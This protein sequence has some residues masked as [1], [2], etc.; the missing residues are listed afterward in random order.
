[1]FQFHNLIYSLL[2]LDPKYRNTTVKKDL[3]VKI[4]AYSIHFFIS[5]HN[6]WKVSNPFRIRR[7]ETNHETVKRACFGK[8]SKISRFWI[9]EACHETLRPVCFVSVG[10][11]PLHLAAEAGH[12]LVLEALL[13]AKANLEAIDDKGKNIWSL[14]AIHNKVKT[15][16]FKSFSCSEVKLQDGDDIS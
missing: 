16:G 10:G 9:F 4:R 14:E 15:Y 8:D 13:K 7:L 6:L 2:L 12:A 11:T 5:Y 1:M 3:K